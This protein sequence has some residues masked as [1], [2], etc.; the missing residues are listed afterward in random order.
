[1]SEKLSN[2][3]FVAVLEDTFSRGQELIFTPSGVSMLPMLDGKNDKVT[4]SPKP[5]KVKKY[6]VLFYRRR[7]T[8]QLVLHRL[9]GFDKDGSYI[10]SGDGQYYFEH[11]IVYDDILAIMSSF[12]HK[13]KHHELT[14]LSYRIY[15]RYMMI[16]KVSRIGLKK[17]YRAIFKR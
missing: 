4:F 7:P 15:I 10:F 1:M 17:I 8:G 3:E 13:G 11:G 14:D 2:A 6:D 12:T 16:R 5:D 9:V